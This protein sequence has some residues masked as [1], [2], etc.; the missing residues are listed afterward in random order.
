MLR[1]LLGEVHQDARAG[2]DEDDPGRLGIEPAKIAGQR[3]P[4]DLRQ[5]AGQLDAGRT[6]A[7]HHERRPGPL[8]LG[9]G[10]QLGR[11]EGAQNAPPDVQR[12]AHCLQSRRVRRPLVV[13]EIG[14]R[15]PGRDDEV[16]VVEVT[17]LEQDALLFH[18]DPLDGAHED[19]DV[20]LAPEQLADR[21]RDVRG[22]QRRGRHLV[23]QRLE[24]VMVALVDRA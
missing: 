15:H 10:L 24:Q 12:V 2:L 5:R 3:P 19:R 4:G 17:V 20:A 18:L 8:G 13:S 7:D 9:V 6:A 1:Q 16:V 21:R 22:G 23:E 14:V 11:L